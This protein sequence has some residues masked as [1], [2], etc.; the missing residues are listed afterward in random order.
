M[1]TEKE[2]NPT[3]DR[4]QLAAQVRQA[5]LEEMRKAVAEKNWT[6]L[7]SIVWL[8]QGSSLNPAS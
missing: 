3:T 4:K 5:L 7:N 6:K 8:M 1:Y 2:T